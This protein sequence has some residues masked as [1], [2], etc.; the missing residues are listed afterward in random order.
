MI[1]RTLNHYRV[2]EKLGSGG[3]GEVYL[4]EDTRLNRKVALKVLPAL[5]ASDP[6]RRE[7]FE[8]EAQAVA[9]LN[10][11]NIVTI[12]SVEEAEGLHFIIM[13]LIQGR[14][15]S[16]LIPPKGLPLSRF[17]DLAI[18][19]ADAISA[20]HKRGITHRDL[21]PDNIMLSDDGRVKI[22]DFGLVKLQEEGAGPMATSLPTAELTAEGRILGTAAYMSPEQAE[23]KPV[24]HRSD[25]FSLGVVFYLMATG[26]KPFQGETR[27]SILSAILR[28]TPSSVTDLNPSLPRHLGRIIRRC[29]AKNPEERYQTS[30]DLK[31]ELVELRKEVD[32]GMGEPPAAVATAQPRRARGR[33]LALAGAGALAVGA[34]AFL[35]YWLLRPARPTALPQAPPVQG[36][37]TQLTD[38]AGE[39]VTPSL[40]PDGRMLS[41]ASREGGNWAIY[42]QSVSGR[43]AVN[44][45]KDSSTNNLQP[46]FSPDGQRIAFRSE[47]EDGGIFVMGVLGD[48]VVRLTDSGYRPAWSPDG[49]E[50]AYETE[51]WTDPLGRATTSQLWV[52]D[53]QSRQKRKIFDG[54]AV[55]PAWSPN[56]SRIAYWAVVGGSGQRDLFSIPSGG[57]EPVRI[58]EDTALD[59]NPAW[60]PDGQMLYFISDRDGSMNIWRVPIDEATGKVQGPLQSVTQGVSGGARDL[61]ISADGHRLVYG[62]EVMSRNIVRFAFDPSAGK[63]EGDPFWVT[64]GSEPVN[65]PDPSPDGEWVAFIMQGKK[66]DLFVSRSDGSGRRQ[67]TDDAARD[68]IPRWSP[69]GKKIAF[70]SD[71]SGSYEIWTINPDGSGLTQITDAPGHTLLY[72]IW[73]PDGAR[74]SVTDIKGDA[75]CLFDPSRPWGQ[76]ARETLPPPEESGQFYPW[77]WSPDGRKLAG[78]IYKG[79]EYNSGVV[80][81]DLQERKYRRLT[82]RGS[83]PVW[84]A[85]SRRLLTSDLSGAALLLDSQTKESRPILSVSPDTLD[86]FSLRISHDNRFI[87]LLRIDRQS[88]LWMLTLQ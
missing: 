10:H 12:H 84:L 37:F 18:P 58:T 2:L 6:E 31:N 77:S 14:N 48:S 69:D 87:Q 59:W 26:A 70:Y 34:V 78:T 62:S 88:D 35:G 27:M 29:L 42:V 65:S 55:Q 16:Q 23:G 71:R 74:M 79:A 73:S 53:T 19:M 25:I 24:D 85:D 20:A 13:E 1:G 46:A 17:F 47:R 52:V 56:G 86:P 43:N 38:Q 45:T 8:R 80:I 28:D 3:M 11:P 68:R 30:Q 51:G 22:L 63:V 57:G 83:F 21:K 82:D 39:E 72:P 41:F 33:S 64:R 44:V 81:Y 66:E 5:M 50:I 32:S 9:A 60:S 61:S 76:Q 40:S 75:S 7:R 67:L 4:A 54:D 49:K 36:S 15:L